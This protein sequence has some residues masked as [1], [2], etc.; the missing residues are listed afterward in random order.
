MANVEEVV[1][2]I[3]EE[4]KQRR[5]R[6][7]NKPP[8][9]ECLS[10]YDIEVRLDLPSSCKETDTLS[11]SITGGCQVHLADGSLGILLVRL[12]RRDHDAR[13]Q[14]G[15]PARLVPSTHL[16]GCVEHRLFDHHLG[17]QDFFP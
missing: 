9:S 3:G 15:V 12:G 1:E 11:L 7:A 16:A 4:E 10:L 13:E 2:E 6:A 5:E 17:P 8:L 14:G